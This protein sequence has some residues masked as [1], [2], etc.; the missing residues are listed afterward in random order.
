MEY[1]RNVPQAKSGSRFSRLVFLLGWRVFRF[2]GLWIATLTAGA[3]YHSSRRQFATVGIGVCVTLVWIAEV[4]LDAA[5]Q[6][7]G[8]MV[9]A[10]SIAVWVFLLSFAFSSRKVR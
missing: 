7:T 3:T 8:A 4:F 10:G 2:T 5:A 6:E 1:P 9:T